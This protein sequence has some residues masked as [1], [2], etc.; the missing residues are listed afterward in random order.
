[1]QVK[2][3]QVQTDITLYTLVNDNGMEVSCLN[4]GGVITKIMA[5]DRNNNIENVVLGF[6]NLDDYKQNPTY[7]GALIGRV[8]GRIQGSQFELDNEVY[9]LEANNEENHLHGGSHGFH[10]AIWDV[11]P[12]ENADEVGLKLSHFSPDGEGGYPGNL[13]VNVTYTLN[14]KNELAISYQANSDHKTALTLT[15][16]SYFNLSGNLKNDIKNHKVTL[17]SSK[18]VELDAELIPTGKQL[19]VE[20]TVFDFQLGRQIIDGVKSDYDQNLNAGKGYDH[21]F[22]FD[23]TRPE[24][25]IVEDQQSGRKLIVTTDQP[26]MVMY[27]SNSLDDSLELLEGPSKQHLGICLETQASPASLHHEG[28]PSVILNKDETYTA[29][30]T[31][32]FDVI[33]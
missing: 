23:H 29:K 11:A 28:F 2:S 13:Q 19:S 5:P 32:T 8:A 25:A 12:F 31:F 14:N 15:N 21:Y 24:Q 30:T 27:T 9:S 7:F 20:N 6:R 4:L 33:K 1:M 3:E 18:F 17:N 22:L 16:H 10:A 26:G